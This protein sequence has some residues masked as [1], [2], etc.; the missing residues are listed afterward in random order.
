MS[1]LQKFVFP[2][3]Q[4]INAKAFD[5]IRNKDEA[6]AITKHNSSDCKCKFISTKCNSQ[7]KWNNKTC[8]CECKNYRKYKENHSW[9][10][11]TCICENSKY[12]KSIA[13]TSV[14]KCDEIVIVVDNLLSQKTNTIAT[15]VTN[16]D[17]GKKSK[18][19]SFCKNQS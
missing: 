1:Y 15:N 17:H 11:S 9:N 4:D 16:T 13:D 7:Q 8:Q 19:L 14:T 12:L 2:K 5:M 10:T 18:K 3:K 6:K